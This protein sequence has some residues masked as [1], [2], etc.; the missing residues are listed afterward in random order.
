MV[1]IITANDAQYAL[2]LV[3]AICTQVGP[4]IPGSAQERERAAMI[5]RELEAHLGAGNVTL[6]E[7]SL[8][9]RAFLGAQL[10]STAFMLAAAVLNISMGGLTGV[11]AWLA[12]A[13]AVVLSGI[14]VLLFIFEFVLGFEVVDRFFNQKQSVN[15]IGKLRK[16]GT[17]DVKR[18]L[19][20]SG[21]HDSALEFTWL[22]YTGYGYFILTITWMMALIMVLGMCLIQLAGVVSGEAGIVRTGSLG[23]VVLVYPIAP[24]VMYALFFA[25]GWKNGGVV[26]GAADNLSACGLV[27]AMCRFL[28]KNPAYIPEDTEV[29]FITFGS[30]E[31]GVRGSRRYV[32]RHLDE[33]RRL[34]ARMINYETIAH[35]QVAILTSET[36]G[37]V[38]NSAE[39]VM[40]VAAEAERAGVPYK[41]KPAHLGTGSDAGPFSR[42]GIKATTLLGFNIQ[43]MVAFYHQER[44]RPEVLGIEPLLNVLKLTFEWLRSG[45]EQAEEQR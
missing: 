4:G 12:A 20:L 33:L 31:A 43:Q 21:H 36:N 13:A 6:E 30:E 40:S 22:R 5:Y 39:M 41:V 14:S 11:S 8:A 24:A 32:R 15:V 27:A 38:K 1:E 37:T 28:V 34:D 25:R 17:Q 2:E 44:D 26:P 42:A 35:P 7:F 10:I 19:I 16:P 23:W 9:P 29:R 45:G 18:M 3:K